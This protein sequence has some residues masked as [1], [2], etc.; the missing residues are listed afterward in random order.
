[1]CW[2]RIVV[3]S[4]IRKI[5]TISK[6]QKSTIAW[7]FATCFYTNKIKNLKIIEFHPKLQYIWTYDSHFIHFKSTH[8]QPHLIFIHHFPINLLQLW[9]PHLHSN[10]LSKY[11][12]FIKPKTQLSSVQ[13]LEKLLT[14]QLIL[15]M[16]IADRN[17][18]KEI[19]SLCLCF[20]PSLLNYAKN[21]L[22]VRCTSHIEAATTNLEQPLCI[23]EKMTPPESQRK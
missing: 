9:F 16:V 2:D 17:F 13:V 12:H 19:I 10:N 6:E 7:T 20:P 5:S 8:H 23:R 1:M 15:I 22:F 21:N 3:W 11:L 18:A 4:A 14:F